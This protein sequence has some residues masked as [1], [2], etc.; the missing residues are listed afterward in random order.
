[1]CSI[2]Y[3]PSRNQVQNIVVVIAPSTIPAAHCSSAAS[4]R[5][6]RPNA[7]LNT[8]A[9][10][11]FNPPRQAR[12]RT[13]WPSSVRV[14]TFSGKECPSRPRS[15]RLDVQKIECP[16]HGVNH[17]DLGVPRDGLVSMVKY[18]KQVRPCMTCF[19]HCC[20]SIQPCSI[21][22]DGQLKKGLTHL[23]QCYSHH[24]LR[25]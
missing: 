7:A 3:C 20:R 17:L 16:L 14:T 10:S 24:S 11:S 21:T 9:G 13:H 19:R 5:T 18:C 1:M 22:L 23:E 8:A 2:T 25:S 6:I 15:R 4:P 12:C